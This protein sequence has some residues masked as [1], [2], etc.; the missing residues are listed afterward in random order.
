MPDSYAV[1]LDVLTH[2][3]G[4]PTTEVSPHRELGTLELDS[5]ARAELALIL[6]ERL[7]VMCSDQDVPPGVTVEALAGLLD[8]RAPCRPRTGP[9]EAG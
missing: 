7:G 8:A 5:L 4:V 9:A 2:T 6:K 3:F 1:V